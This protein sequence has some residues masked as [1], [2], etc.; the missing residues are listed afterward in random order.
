[1]EVYEDQFSHSTKISLNPHE[2]IFLKSPQ[3]LEGQ[4]Q[5]DALHDG[6]LIFTGGNNII[7][8]FEGIDPDSLEFYATPQPFAVAD[9]A[10]FVVDGQGII[11]TT[12]K[13]RTTNT[14]IYI[15][16][17]GEGKLTIAGGQSMIHGIIDIEL[18]KFSPQNKDY[19]II[20]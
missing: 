11:L 4:V 13:S 18:N 1:M 14:C 8:S 10:S 2:R 6:Q 3:P 20:K 19:P 5:I 9:T 15:D 17:N 7:S 16:S 12:P